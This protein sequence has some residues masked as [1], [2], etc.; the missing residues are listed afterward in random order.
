MP[1]RLKTVTNQLKTFSANT[2]NVTSD[3]INSSPNVFCYQ[4]NCQ[5]A[6]RDGFKWVRSA[7]TT[8]NGERVKV[9]IYSKTMFN[10]NIICMI[11]INHPSVK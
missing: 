1:H 4:V 8:L 6:T 5:R 9:D 7:D 11:E 10:M 3:I 2:N